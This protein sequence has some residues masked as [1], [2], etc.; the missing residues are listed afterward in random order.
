MILEEKAINGG[1]WNN[2]LN[3]RAA[4]VIVSGKT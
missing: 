4:A 3:R 1:L 2:K